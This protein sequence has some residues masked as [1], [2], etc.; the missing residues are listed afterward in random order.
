MI[1]AKD[2]GTSIK[3]L[4]LISSTK[5]FLFSGAKI[6]ASPMSLKYSKTKQKSFSTFII[7][8]SLRNTAKDMSIK[9]IY[10]I[11]VT[12]SLTTS[13]IASLQGILINYNIT[14]WMSWVELSENSSTYTSKMYV[15]FRSWQ[16]RRWKWTAGETISRNQETFMSFCSKGW[17]KSNMTRKWP[18]VMSRC[19][20]TVKLLKDDIL[21]L[22]FK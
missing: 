1:E 10:R 14:P 21:L 15:P 17:A 22:F 2:W 20:V 8:K 16:A 7:S 18:K 5:Y 12:T 6:R 19:I 9:N 3:T 13:H 4:N 11:Y